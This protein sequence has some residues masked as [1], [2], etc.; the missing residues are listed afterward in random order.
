LAELLEKG[1]IRP[2]VSPFGS[3][4][5]F[6]RK[7]NGEL[8]LCID[9]RA[10]NKLTVRNRYPLPRIDDLLDQLKGAK[11]FSSMDLKAGYNQIRIHEDDVEKTAITTPFGHWEYLVLPMG[12]ANAPSIFMALM[13]DVFKGM[14]HFC[15]VYLDDVLVYSNSP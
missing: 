15:L 6:V 12:M 13:N 3:P 8:R 4:V 9:Y 14:E 5:I 1:L 7:P 11:C 10:V 2:S